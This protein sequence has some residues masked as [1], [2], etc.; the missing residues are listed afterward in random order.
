MSTLS[1]LSGLSE[2][3]IQMGDDLDCTIVCSREV[4]MTRPPTSPCLA[5]AVCHHDI[6]GFLVFQQFLAGDSVPALTLAPTTTPGT[7]ATAATP[8]GGGT[9][10]RV[11]ATPAG[12]AGTWSVGDSS[13]VGY[14]VRE[15]LGGVTALTDA[16]GRTSAVTGTA[17]VE[18]D[19]TGV[20]VSGRRVRGRPDPAPERRGPARQPDPV[21]GRGV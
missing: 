1:I 10:A 14:R 8:R 7:A 13:V 9:S 16:G 18:A 21:D 12:I 15:Q 5:A 6:G 3:L 11:D 20:R 17:T 19:G 4:P 2:R